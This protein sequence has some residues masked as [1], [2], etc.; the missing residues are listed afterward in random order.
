MPHRE[1]AVSIP[2]LS[3]PLRLPSPPTTPEWEI[4]GLTRNEPEDKKMLLSSNCVRHNMDLNYKSEFKAD[5]KFEATP[6]QL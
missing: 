5:L 4:T 6:N 3:Q 2:L 1:L